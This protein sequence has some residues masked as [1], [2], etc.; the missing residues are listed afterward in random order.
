MALKLLGEILGITFCLDSPRIV[1]KVLWDKRRI[2]LE[3][4]ERGTGIACTRY[5]I[6][7]VPLQRLEDDLGVAGLLRKYGLRVSRRRLA[8][9]KLK[10]F[11][12]TVKNFFLLIQIY[13]LE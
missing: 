11:V 8:H 2:T 4:L 9:S 6:T 12:L 13:F 1:P 7:S 3:I 10:P 5:G